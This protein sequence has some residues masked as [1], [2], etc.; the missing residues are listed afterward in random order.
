MSTLNKKAENRFPLRFHLS[1][2]HKTLYICSMILIK[3][4]PKTAEFL[5]QINAIKLNLKNP[6][7][8]HRL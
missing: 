7:Y 5:L 4:Q 1:K 2:C 8:G 6:F 3:I